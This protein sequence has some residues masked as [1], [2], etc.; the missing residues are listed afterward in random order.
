MAWLFKE[1]VRR[2]SPDS[3][4]LLGADRDTQKGR[5]GP[6]LAYLRPV[7]SKCDCLEGVCSGRTHHQPD[8]FVAS[9]V[10]GQDIAHLLPRRMTMMRSAMAKMSCRLWLMMMTGTFCS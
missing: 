4:G 10:A 6:R 9:D 8:Y 1:L 5:R 3:S 2:D 7:D